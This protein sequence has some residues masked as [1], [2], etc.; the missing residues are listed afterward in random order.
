[1]AAIRRR[2]EGQG[3]L[4]AMMPTENASWVDAELT[5]RFGPSRWSFT[6]T[7]TDANRWAI[8]LARHVT[9][10]AKILVFAWC[11]HRSVDE[12]FALPGPDGAAISRDG[13]IGAPVDL[14]VTTRVVDFN[15]LDALATAALGREGA[16]ARKPPQRERG[17]DGPKRL[18]LPAEQRPVELLGSLGIAGVK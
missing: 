18:G 16:I 6:L 13:S 1:M 3:G 4:T 2:I 14:A 10:R 7:T 9:G 11:C 17:I 15:D 5:R 8:R 12:T